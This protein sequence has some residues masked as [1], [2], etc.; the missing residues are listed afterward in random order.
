MA[1]ARE[2][3]LVDRSYFYW[4]GGLSILLGVFVL[5]W[6]QLTTL[7]LV[8]FISIWLLLIGVISIVGGVGSIRRGGWGWVASILLGILELGVGA[9]LVQ[10]PGV[11]L[12]TIVSLLGL[13]FVV[14]GFVY[15]ANTFFSPVAA[16]GHRALSLL[17]GILSL[18]AGIWIWR[19]PLH[20]TLAFVWLVGL[21]AIVSGAMQIAMA[22]EVRR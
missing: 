12:L 13:V 21:Y 17:F 10:R 18:V 5:V 19:Y 14:Q 9:Y 2:L 3:E 6:P 11:T 15:V 8:T 1:S 20:G 22:S 16:G 4:R 7:V